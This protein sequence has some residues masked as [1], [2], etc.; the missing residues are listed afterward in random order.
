MELLI[1]AV[2]FDPKADIYSYHSHINISFSLDMP[3]YI[4]I[5]IY[6]HTDIG[7]NFGEKREQ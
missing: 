7:N 3:P 2:C 6:T 1:T 5:Y 4:Y